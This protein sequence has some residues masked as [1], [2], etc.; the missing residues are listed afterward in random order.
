MKK[1]D[2]KNLRILAK[3]GFVIYLMAM[4]YFLFF[5]EKMGRVSSEEYRYNL[6]PFEEINRCLKYIDRYSMMLNLF[7][8]VACFV[9]LGF[10]LP[11]LKSRRWNFIKVTLLSLLASGLVEVMQL[12]TRLGSCDVDD[13][14]LNTCGGMTGYILFLICRGIY[15]LLAKKFQKNKF[16]KKSDD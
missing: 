9:P 6:K 7:G 10:I 2:M 16:Q 15:R 3:I 11:F 8:N 12:L 13:I 14:I 4:V 1:W 5:C